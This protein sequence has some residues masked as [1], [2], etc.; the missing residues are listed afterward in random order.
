MKASLA[1]RAAAIG[2]Q[3][4]SYADARGTSQREEPPAETAD[5][6]THWHVWEPERTLRV[7]CD[8]PRTA[9]ELRAIFPAMTHAFPWL[10]A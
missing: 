7:L 3:A 4:R 9:D 8:E 10:D 2:R 5:R 1:E 6:R